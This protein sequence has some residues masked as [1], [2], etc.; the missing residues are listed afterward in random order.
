MELWSYGVMELWSYGVKELSQMFGCRVDGNPCQL[1][2]LKCLVAER[3][4][5][6]VNS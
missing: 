3:T 2:N 5:I 4:A 1:V 6:L